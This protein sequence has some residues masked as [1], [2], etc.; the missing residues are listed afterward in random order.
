MIVKI[1]QSL[2]SSDGLRHCLIYDKKRKVFYEADTPEE[3]DPLVKLLSERP[4]AYFNAE[5]DKKRK[6]IILSEAEDQDW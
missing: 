4:K 5:L 1:Q 2:S 3:V 6:I